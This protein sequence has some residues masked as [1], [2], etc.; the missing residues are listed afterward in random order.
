MMELVAASCVAYQVIIKICQE[1]FFLPSFNGREGIF[2]FLERLEQFK[3]WLFPSL[4]PKDCTVLFLFLMI[5]TYRLVN[6][7]VRCEALS[8]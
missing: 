2:L 3:V 1:L 8:V 5:R 6:G 7:R 4:C